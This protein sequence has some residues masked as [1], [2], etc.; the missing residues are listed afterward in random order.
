MRLRIPAAVAAVLVAVL[1]AFV[2]PAGPATAAFPPPK[3]FTEVD[4]YK[5][6]GKVHAYAVK[7]CTDD[8]PPVNLSLW[9]EIQVCDAGGCL[10]AN[11][12]YG[13]G[14]VSDSCANMGPG[15]VRSSRLRSKV[16][17]C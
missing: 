13:V 6:N 3:C 12:K 9:L 5:A 7:T 11:W 16:M 8:S 17:D 2:A 14:S 10:W 15:P 1:A 4:T